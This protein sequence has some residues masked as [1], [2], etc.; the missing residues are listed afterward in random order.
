MSDD[1]DSSKLMATE[2]KEPVSE[3]NL[4]WQPYTI[5]PVLRAKQKNQQPKLLWFTGLSGAGKSTI[6]NI[7][8]KKLFDL[9]LHSFVLDGD[10]VRQGLCRDL[11]FSDEDRVENIRRV[12]EVAKL[13]TDAGLIV[14]AAFISPFT[15]DRDLVRNM[16]RDGQF[17]EIFIDAPLQVVEQRDVKGLYK[18]ARAGHILDF[19]GIGSVYERPKSP[20][21]HIASDMHSA[22]AAA[23]LILEKL[24][25]S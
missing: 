4:E 1:L 16:F 19:T 18:K 5:G 7:L 20:D 8:D 25:L 11:G 21:I 10:N 22:E 9:G 24:S 3:P 15:K 6:A 2:H 23:E 14:L 13:M 12:G 17:Y